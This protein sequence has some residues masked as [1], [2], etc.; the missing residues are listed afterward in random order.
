M[1]TP[2]ARARTAR[3]L[4][5]PLRP[6]RPRHHCPQTL[7]SRPPL[8]P[9]APGHGG[10]TREGGRGPSHPGPGRGDQGL[11]PTSAP[12]RGSVTA[13]HAADVPWDPGS[14]Q[15]PLAL[16]DPLNTKA[17]I[18]SQKSDHTL[19]KNQTQKG[20]SWKSRFLG[21]RGHGGCGLPWGHHRARPAPPG[22][23]SARQVAPR[24]ETLLRSH[25]PAGA[26]R[27]GHL[28][29]PPAVPPRTRP[30]FLAGPASRTFPV[31]SLV[32]RKDTGVPEAGGVRAT[33]AE[34]P[35]ARHPGRP[36]SGCEA[37]R[38]VRGAGTSVLRPR[39]GAALL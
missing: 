25:V 18:R 29:H 4:D 35:D 24:Q 30:A 38:S 27:P 37:V 7:P 9:E 1:R 16:T 39:R 26:H 17:E 5:G 31:T 19:R 15:H 13:M 22:R 6:R 8:L 10:H 23:A 11:T 34:P 12:A 21:R 2:P 33:A 20:T 32:K 3:S 28:A 14:R 36:R